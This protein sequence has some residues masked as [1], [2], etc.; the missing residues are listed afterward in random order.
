[1]RTHH[2]V[3]E[4]TVFKALLIPPERGAL[5]KKRTHV[6]V[7]RFDIVLLV[8]FASVE[9][10][11]NFQGTDAWMETLAM[12]KKSARKSVSVAASNARRIGP[13]DHSRDGV[14]G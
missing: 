5:L 2:D 12:A 11:E 7:A 6:E 4:A 9:T 10:A 3:V 1:M 13:V 14:C 8:E